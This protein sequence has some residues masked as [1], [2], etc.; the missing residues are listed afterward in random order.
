MGVKIGQL[1]SLSGGDL[2]TLVIPGDYVLKSTGNFTNI[3][4]ALSG[5]TM[6]LSVR[7]QNLNTTLLAQ[8]LKVAGSGQQTWYRRTGA[9]DVGYKLHGTFVF[10]SWYGF[11]GA[12]TSS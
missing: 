6:L 9:Q 3:P 11:V 1:I 12:A 4:S 7:Y 2:N 10:N 8:E 5:R